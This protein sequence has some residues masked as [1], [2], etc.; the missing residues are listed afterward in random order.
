[1]VCQ[2]IELFIGRI[3]CRI[4]FYVVGF[5]PS[6]TIL[7]LSR[8]CLF[9][10]W[11]IANGRTPSK[12][13]LGWCHEKRLPIMIKTVPDRAMLHLHPAS[14]TQASGLIFSS[15][16]QPVGL[17]RFLSQH[18]LYIPC[19][20]SFPPDQI[21]LLCCVPPALSPLLLSLADWMEIASG[22]T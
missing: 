5:Y 4:E 8:D 17:T 20:A 18:L 16:C 1:V 10:P 14:C 12:S 22:V 9:A 21:A 13:M 15:I 3:G 7:G 19:N 2:R 6:N 11:E